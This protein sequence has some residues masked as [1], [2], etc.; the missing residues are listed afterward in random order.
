MCTFAPLACQK[1]ILFQKVTRYNEFMTKHGTSSL[2]IFSL[3]PRLFLFLDTLDEGIHQR[4]TGRVSFSSCY[5]EHIAIWHDIR[6]CFF[7]HGQCVCTCQNR[8]C[9]SSRLRPPNRLHIIVF[10]FMK[11][12]MSFGVTAANTLIA[13]TWSQAYSFP[14]SQLWINNINDA[15]IHLYFVRVLVSTMIVYACFAVPV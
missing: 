4:T 2:Q 14:G 15:R 12:N 7:V 5:T 11:L 10:I 9:I 8:V 13:W 1:I 3:L 6:N